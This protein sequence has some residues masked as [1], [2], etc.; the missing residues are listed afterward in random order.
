M[1]GN[2]PSNGTELIP[3]KAPEGSQRAT[4]VEF[5]SRGNSTANGTNI[6]ATVVA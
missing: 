2:K 1:G 5:A 3:A 6:A 4:S